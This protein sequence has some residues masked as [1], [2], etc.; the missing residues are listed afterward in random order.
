MIY[1]VDVGDE[2]ETVNVLAYNIVQKMLSCLLSSND[3][4]VLF[5]DRMS[6]ELY[7]FKLYCCLYIQYIFVKG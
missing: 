3:N 4:P 2:T 5:A 6:V 7:I 1:K